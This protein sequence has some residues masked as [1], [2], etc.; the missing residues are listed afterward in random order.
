MSDLPS[1]AELAM[2]GL[3]PLQDRVTPP[4]TKEY[5]V[6]VPNPLV[7]GSIVAA[8]ISARKFWSP[9]QRAERKE[10]RLRVNV[11]YVGRAKIGG[12]TL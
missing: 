5:G 7:T 10:K 6:Y 8:T 3:E 11:K 12:V 2:M 1:R 4:R 9:E